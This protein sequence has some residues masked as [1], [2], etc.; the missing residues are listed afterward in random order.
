VNEALAIPDELVW[1]VMVLLV[2]LKRPE[3][4]VVGAVKTTLAPETTLPELSFTVTASGVKAVLIVTDCGVV[5]G[6]VVMEPGAPAVLAR[7]NEVES[8]PVTAVTL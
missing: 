2:L 6:F 4:P 7:E 8:V 5:P 1:T 3:A